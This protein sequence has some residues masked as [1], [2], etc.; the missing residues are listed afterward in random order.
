[1]VVDG[2]GESASPSFERTNWTVL[3][4]PLLHHRRES[5]EAPVIT[6]HFNLLEYLLRH[7]IAV[8]IL[9]VPLLVVVVV[10]VE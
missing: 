10:S 3:G 6:V 9:V 2:H 5:P 8:V 4:P 1:V 7:V